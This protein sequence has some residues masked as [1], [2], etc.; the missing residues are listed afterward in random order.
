[1][2]SDLLGCMW[3]WM[4]SLTVQGANTNS[5]ALGH[6]AAWRGEDA[7]V[8]AINM[9]MTNDIILKRWSPSGFTPFYDHHKWILH[10]HFPWST[11]V[12][13]L[14]ELCESN[15][16]WHFFSYFVPGKGFRCNFL[17]T[18]CFWLLPSHTCTLI[19]GALRYEQSAQQRQRKG[20][21]FP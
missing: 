11:C 3:M 13:G 16:I 1:M 15:I 20:L 2:L 21:V 4:D 7:A 17:S 9:V 18:F 8:W 14:V 12:I 6:P 10:T 5:L 19:P